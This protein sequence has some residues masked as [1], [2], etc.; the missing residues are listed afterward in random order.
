MI[1]QDRTA[2]IE[3]LLPAGSTAPP[4]GAQVRV[5]GEVGRAY[6]APRIRAATVLRVGT[7]PSTPLELR[8]APGAAHEW[9][10]VRVRGDVVEVHRSGDRWTAELRVGGARIPIAGL[11][12][13]ADSRPPPSRPVEAPRSSG[14]SG[15]RIRPPRIGGSRS[16][17]ADPATWR[18]AAPRTIRHP[19]PGPVPA[20]PGPGAPAQAARPAAAAAASAPPDLDLADLAAHVGQVVR[21]GGLVGHVDADG[22]RLDDGTA[23]AWVR[24]GAGAADLARSMLVGDALSAIGRVERDP[25]D[26]LALVVVDDPGGI[27]LVGGLGPDP[28]ASVDASAG[29][30]V[31]GAGRDLGRRAV[32]GSAPPTDGAASAGSACPGSAPSASSCRSRIAG[33]DAPPAATHAAP[34]R[35]PHRGPSRSP[36]SAA[37]PARPGRRSRRPR[38]AGPHRA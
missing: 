35:G 16:S 19:E 2:A 1:V 26:G 4:L 37:G 17:R 21:V 6:G 5:T 9:R 27:A 23:V 28:S 14:S 11:A 8:V 33:R 31:R 18:S 25:G 20:R 24:L 12:G 3:V 30:T 32:P 34:A 36:S 22:F 13:S 10:L 15:G 38:W 29:G 7:E